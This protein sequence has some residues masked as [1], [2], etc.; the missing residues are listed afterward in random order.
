MPNVSIARMRA[1]SAPARSR[2][3][4]SPSTRSTPARTSVALGK[5]LGEPS[6]WRIEITAKPVLEPCDLAPQLEQ[7]EL[8]PALGIADVVAPLL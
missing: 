7:P 8:E 2:Y 4:A 1:A 6:L 3:P 5:P